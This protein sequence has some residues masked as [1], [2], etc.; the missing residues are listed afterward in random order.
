MKISLEILKSKET[1]KKKR[2][3]RGP[4]KVSIRIRNFFK[5]QTENGNGS[6]TTKSPLIQELKIINGQLDRVL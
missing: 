4:T 3:I 1:L 5:R 2:E 6:T